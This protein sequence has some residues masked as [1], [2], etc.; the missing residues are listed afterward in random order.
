MQLVTE[1]RRGFVVVARS[2]VSFR[3]VVECFEPTCYDGA[4]AVCSVCGVL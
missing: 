2:L 3:F 4:E 1:S